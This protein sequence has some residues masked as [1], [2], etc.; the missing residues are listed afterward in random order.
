M[1]HARV[2]LGQQLRHLER[3]G[4]EGAPYAA[5]IVADVF[6]KSD[7][8]GTVI[9]IG[10]CCLYIAATDRNDGARGPCLLN[11]AGGPEEVEEPLSIIAVSMAIRIGIRAERSYFKFY[12]IVLFAKQARKAVQ[13]VELQAY[14]VDLRILTRF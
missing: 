13:L 3:L 10:V 5:E 2:Q 9:F 12:M 8:A 11:L 4:V 7:G 1:A 6:A 14:E